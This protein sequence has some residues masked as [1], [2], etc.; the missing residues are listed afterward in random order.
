VQRYKTK[1][2]GFLESLLL[3]VHITGGQPGRGTELTSL[4]HINTISDYHRNIFADHGMINT[5]TTYHKGYSI[6]GSAKI[7]HRF[8]PK[9]V[10]EL[11]VYYLR[12]VLSFCQKLDLL[13]F[14]SPDQPSSFLWPKSGGR[15]SWG[16][17]RLSRVLKREFMNTIG[18]PMS[19][20][21]WR[22]LAIAISRKHLACG[23]FKR[24]YDMDETTFDNQSCHATR[25]ARSIYARGLEEAA[26]HIEARKESYRKVSQEWHAFLGF[27]P[28]QLLPTRNIHGTLEDSSR[29]DVLKP[30]SD[31]PKR[32]SKDDGSR[33]PAKK[34]RT[35]V[36]GRC[37]INM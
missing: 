19:I 2:E 35:E 30:L 23:G 22:H 24:D 9:E 1:V 20:V 11:L 27:L 26:D 6:T 28:A 33:G 4:R 34:V 17:E 36:E 37:T 18:V 31:Q 29:R 25:T 16:S 32:P 13:V 15:D 8:L 7:I 3:L 10:G 21:V 14:R 12:L 5:V